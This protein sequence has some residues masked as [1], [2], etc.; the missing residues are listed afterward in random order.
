M[1]LSLTGCTHEGPHTGCDEGS[2]NLLFTYDGNTVGFD[3]TI[4]EDIEL[5]L[6]DGQGKKMDERHIPYENI[7][8]GKPYP[9]KLSY[10][11]N[12]YL[13]AWTLTGNEDIKKTSPALHDDES[14][15]TAR[16][17][18]GTLPEKYGVYP[19]PTGKPYSQ[20]RCPKTVMQHFRHHRRRKQ[21]LNPIPRNTQ[22]GH[23]RFIPFIQYC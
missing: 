22:H 16:F 14:Y 17:S 21:L 8:G 7:K 2:L 11:G 1:A 18:A 9:L 12:A 23:L 10:S 13:V 3:Q 4:A 5:Y 19:Q 15:S 6:Y 20:C